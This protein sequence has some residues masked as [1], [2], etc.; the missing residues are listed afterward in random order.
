MTVQTD[1]IT[2]KGTMY[3]VAIMANSGRDGATGLGVQTLDDKYLT[4][5]M[6]ICDALPIIVPTLLSF[7][8][9]DEILAVVDGVILTG[10]QSNVAPDRYGVNDRSDRL[11]PFDRQRDETALYLAGEA[12]KLGRPLFGICRGMQEINVALGGTLRAGFVGKTD[13]HDHPPIKK[14]NDPKQIYAD[15]HRISVDASTSLGRAIGTTQATVSSVHVQAVDRMG[16]GL[17]PVAMSN[18]GIIEAFESEIDGMVIGVQWHPEYLATASTLSR[19]IFGRF[20]ELLK[21]SR[22]G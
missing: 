16:A 2:A 22:S 20:A 17:R 10:D 11:G 9:I 19:A 7:A 15:A 6:E 13:F 5:T 8:E 18:D 1:K 21:I 3:K 12:I 4:A 14:S